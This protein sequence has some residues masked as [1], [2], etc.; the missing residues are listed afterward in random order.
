MDAGASVR[1]IFAVRRSAA[2][3]KAFLAGVA[4]LLSWRRPHGI[5]R[6]VDQVQLFAG[7]VIHVVD[8]DN[9]RLVFAS[10]PNTIRLLTQY[11]RPLEATHLEGGARGPV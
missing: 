10:G 9:R 5:L 2:H 3:L 6:I 1:R 8:V 11:E 4:R 7:A